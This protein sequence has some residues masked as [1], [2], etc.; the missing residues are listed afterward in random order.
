MSH[1]S[2]YELS[3]EVV[4]HDIYTFPSFFLL[5][6]IEKRSSH[7]RLLEHLKSSGIKILMRGPLVCHAREDTEKQRNA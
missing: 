1:S 5:H 7:G 2:R 6:R 4:S 3:T